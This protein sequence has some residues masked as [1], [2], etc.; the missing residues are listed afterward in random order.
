MRMLYKCIAKFLHYEVEITVSIVS[1]FYREVTE[2]NP[3]PCLTKT[4]KGVSKDL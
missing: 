2:E 3:L 4:Y 1:H